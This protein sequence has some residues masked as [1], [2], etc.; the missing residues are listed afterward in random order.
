MWEVTDFHS[1]LN[2]INQGQF[3]SLAI[4]S[5]QEPDDQFLKYRYQFCQLLS[6][7]RQNETNQ[8]KELANA[9]LPICLEYV[10]SW[11][12]F[13][14][15]PAPNFDFLVL[16]SMLSVST[17]PTH[18]LFIKLFGHVMQQ[19]RI[20]N[21]MKEDTVIM[22]ETTFSDESKMKR[23][24]AIVKLE[25]RIDFIA[26]LT[27]SLLQTHRQSTLLLSFLL[28]ICPPTIL[29]SE[30]TKS[31]IGQAALQTGDFNLAQKYF[32]LVKDPK[33]R[34]ANEG[35]KQFYLGKFAEAKQ[36]FEISNINFK[37]CDQYL[38]RIP[39]DEPSLTKKP[40]PEEKSQW[41]ASPQ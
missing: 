20:L 28:D 26:E 25:S 30:I 19:Y 5:K 34:A 35:F 13:D 17:L 3:T 37:A 31:H 1:D 40:T 6:Q 9:F 21:E 23:T 10:D 22:K 7:F 33:L 39:N 32:E 15:K 14:E 16:V 29:H 24:D 27:A 38:G 36:N 18:S 4:E 2:L 11:D 12:S 8:A 41:P